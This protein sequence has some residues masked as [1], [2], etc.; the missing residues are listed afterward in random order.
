MKLLAWA[1]TDTGRKRD[2]NEDSF[3]VDD[4]LRLFAVAD[5]MGGHQGG[6]HA[7]KLALEV[8]RARMDEAKGD[9]V[10]A[11]RRI[12]RE[13]HRELFRTTEPVSAID[14]T[15]EHRWTGDLPT[16][17]IADSAIPPP[18]TVMK[19]AARDAGHAI[20]DAALQDAGLRGMG[21]T[22]TGMLYDD[23]RMYVVHAGDSRLYLFRDGLLRQVTEDH[24]WIAEQM[25]AGN[26]TE[27]EAKESKYRHVITRSVGFEREVE[28]DGV[29][30]ACEPGD[31]FLLCSDGLSNMVDNADLERVLST[32]WY[33]RAP[34]YL[35]DLANARGGDDNVTVI[36][37]CIANDAE[38]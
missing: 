6:E 16:A 17:P 11:A 5:G 35:V 21:T 32:T 24:S 28:V 29:G 10:E 9:L 27:E 2:H 23:G 37:V 13:R 4:E 8:M 38:P 31:C 3:L 34:Q 19:A 12:E 30:L 26:L 36:V 15:A 14:D 20:F 18:L 7:S 25:R 22:L 33:R 1:R